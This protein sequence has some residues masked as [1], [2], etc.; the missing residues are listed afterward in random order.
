MSDKE[1]RQHDVQKLTSGSTE[2]ATYYPID[3]A[4]ENG[5]YILIAE[6]FGT[7]DQTFTKQVRRRNRKM[8]RT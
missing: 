8:V 1:K 7:N 4:D 5:K 2:E 6:T 3:G